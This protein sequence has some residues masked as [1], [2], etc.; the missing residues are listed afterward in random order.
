MTQ[1]DERHTCS[2]W[3]LSDNSVGILP[4]QIKKAGCV[5]FPKVFGSDDV[6]QTFSMSWRFLVS[7]PSRSIC[8][9]S[10]M[11]SCLSS[12][13][14]NRLALS[15]ST[16]QGRTLG[17][18]CPSTFQCSP[19]RTFWNRIN[20]NNSL[21]SEICSHSK[22]QV[23]NLTN[24]TLQFINCYYFRTCCKVLN[25]VHVTECSLTTSCN[26]YYLLRHVYKTY[27]WIITFL[28]LIYI[29]CL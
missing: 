14:N 25:N 1:T 8:H 23:R 3:V 9:L 29:I 22:V 26:P 13:E 4:S 27:K 17:P 7:V 18:P 21:R 11:W 5:F 28:M 15:L 10:D 16:S 19:K 20:A 24:V 6:G 12:W 2:C